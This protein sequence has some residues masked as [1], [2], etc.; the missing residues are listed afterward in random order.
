MKER[1]QRRSGNGRQGGIVPDHGIK[2]VIIDMKRSLYEAVYVTTWRK[3]LLRGW[4]R[5]AQGER[6]LAMGSVRLVKAG[7]RPHGRSIR[8]GCAQD[9]WKHPKR[10]LVDNLGQR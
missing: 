2:L 10:R 4:P 6:R 8:I 3:E 7:R 5:S 1:I 9:S